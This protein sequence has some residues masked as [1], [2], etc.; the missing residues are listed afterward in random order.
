MFMSNKSHWHLLLLHWHLLLLHWLLHSWCHHR[1]VIV[2]D[3]RGCLLVHRLHLH[4]L[5]L[6]LLHLHLHHLLLLELWL[7]VLQL[8]I[9]CFKLR[10]LRIGGNWIGVSFFTAADFICHKTEAAKDNGPHNTSSGF[11]TIISATW[12]WGSIFACVTMSFPRSSVIAN[13]AWHCLE[14][15]TT[16]GFS[17]FNGAAIVVKISVF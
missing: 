4:L 2:D 16:A 10:N 14:I 5:L 12:A 1:L 17:T 13:S 11:I 8:I 6:L 9:F 15:A 7:L 3:R